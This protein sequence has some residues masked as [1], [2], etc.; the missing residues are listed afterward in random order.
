LLGVFDDSEGEAVFD[1][2]QGVEGFDFDVEV[3]AGG[4]EVVD[5]DGGGVAYGAQDVVKLPFH[6]CSFIDRVGLDKK[7]Y[8]RG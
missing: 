5:A 1:G 3:D 2:A 8:P 7:A 6:R 4:G